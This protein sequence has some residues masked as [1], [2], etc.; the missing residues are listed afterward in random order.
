MTVFCWFPSSFIF[1]LLI[2]RLCATL[3]L[4][5][6]DDSHDADFEDFK[7]E[8]EAY[9]QELIRRSKQVRFDDILDDS[10]PGEM[11][12]IRRKL[13]SEEKRTR[14]RSEVSTSF[15]I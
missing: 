5:R 6:L 11:G 3:S 15:I 12:G 8:L 2:K 10:A 14:F 13:A 1:L 4:F 7:S 9:K